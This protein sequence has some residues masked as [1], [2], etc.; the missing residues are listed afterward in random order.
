MRPAIIGIAVLGL[1]VGFVMVFCPTNLRND[2]EE[3][4]VTACSAPDF[5]PTYLP[6]AKKGDLPEPEVFGAQLNSITQWVAPPSYGSAATIGLIR[7]YHPWDDEGKFP[8]VPVHGNEGLLVWV[9]DPGVGELSLHWSE[10][11]EPCDNYGLSMVNRKLG[12]RGAERELARVARSL[13]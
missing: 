10:G 8:K 7:R 13:R 3:K 11:D 4:T 9:G 2:S 1:L 12:E 6:W 5:A